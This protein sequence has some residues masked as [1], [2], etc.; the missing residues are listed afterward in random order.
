MSKKELSWKRWGE[1]AFRQKGQLMPAWCTE[2]WWRGL[3]GC[4]AV[5][6]GKVAQYQGRL[7]IALEAE[8]GC[9]FILSTAGPQR[10]LECELH[11][12]RIKARDP[13]G[14]NCCGLVVSNYISIAKAGH[15][16]F[17]L[18]KMGG[19]PGKNMSPFDSRERDYEAF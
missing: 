7:Y 10:S 13:L 2:G 1:D 17:F 18:W 14:D 9:A 11:E 16:L 12:G 5:G 19:E 8:K 3:C 4:S 15:G 6:R